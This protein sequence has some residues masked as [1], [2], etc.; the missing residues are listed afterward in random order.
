[1]II[2]KKCTDEKKQKQL[3]LNL[4]IYFDKLCKKYSLKYTLYAGTLLGAIRH[5]GFIPWDDDVDVAMPWPDYLK[6]ME[7]PEILNRKSEYIL[8]NSKLEKVNNERYIYPFA[9]LE[10][11]NTLMRFKNI[12]D[13]GGLYLDIFPICDFPESKQEANSLADNI[14]NY[15]GKIEKGLVKPGKFDVYRTIRNKY[16]HKHYKRNRNIMEQILIKQGYGTSSKVGQFIWAN[17]K[18]DLIQEQFPKSWLADYVSVDFE[19][20]EFQALS[21]YLGLLN[22]E[23]GDWT[24]LPPKEDQI[25]KHAYDLY[26]I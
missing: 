11:T 20:Y 12:F 3:L 2:L 5:R 13:G 21:N 9:K 18:E 8:H 16:Y 24:K 10:D 7:I 6:L 23:Y 25:Q 26:L 14:I 1:M 15:K 17:S 4:L 22:L 19:G